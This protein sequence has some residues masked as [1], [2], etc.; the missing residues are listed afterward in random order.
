LSNST[1]AK[2]RNIEGVRPNKR[3]ELLVGVLL[4]IAG[5]VAVTA[6]LLVLVAPQLY[7]PDVEASV[8]Q[9]GI[10]RPLTPSQD[11]AL[12][13]PTTLLPTPIP[14]DASESSSAFLSKSASVQNPVLLPE[15]PVSSDQ[16]N[17]SH[18]NLNQLGL[19][20][21]QLTQPFRL[22][23]PDLFIDAPVR[24]VGTKYADVG[25]DGYLQWNVPNDYAVG[26]H[27]SS[28]VL[29]QPGNTIL[30]GHNNVHGAI[31]RNLADLDLGA[32]LVLY[33]TEESHIYQVT[34][35]E[36]FEEDGQELSVRLAN[37]RWMLPTSDERITI[38]S[39]WPTA[40]NTHRIVVIA[41]P[42]KSDE[43]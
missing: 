27:E 15:S 38:I 24:P 39:C 29:G 23:I 33:D 10:Y 11:P 14:F 41:H 21:A 20:N 9:A 16:I 1:S 18:N 43:S 19:G 28:A 13:R 34:Q 22:V 37:A 2:I 7:T 32:E 26:W 3:G 36:L 25:R 8:M 6:F 5:A 42:V 4:L 40:T 12:P 17:N 31:F 30:N 35:R